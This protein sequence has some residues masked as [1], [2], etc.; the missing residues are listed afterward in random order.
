[1]TNNKIQK[2]TA[3][4]IY[5]YIHIPFWNKRHEN[6]F[7]NCESIRWFELIEIRVICHCRL[8]QC[9]LVCANAVCIS[10]RNAA[11]I[12]HSQRSL[13]PSQVGA[14]ST[15]H[16]YILN[17]LWNVRDGVIEYSNAFYIYAVF[18]MHINS[19]LSR[20]LRLPPK[21][22]CYSNFVLKCLAIVCMKK[23]RHF[24]IDLRV[25]KECAYY[26]VGH[27]FILRWI[28]HFIP[29]WFCK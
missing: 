19:L 27:C 23:W 8:S 3:L 17:L 16:L 6:L 9:A 2:K 24:K 14:N 15:I 1:M 29:F 22:S 20:E 26:F 11:I 21:F 13:K 18:Y 28:E 7:I 10:K 25:G 12:Q 5:I 4:Y